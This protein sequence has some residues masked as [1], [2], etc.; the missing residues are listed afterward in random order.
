MNTAATDPVS[1]SVARDIERIRQWQSDGQHAQALQAAQ[2]LLTEAK[3]HYEVLY[4]VARS[5]RYLGQ[6]DA[7]LQTLARM[8][9]EHPRYSRLHEER[10]HCY[11]VLRDAPNAIDALLHAVNINPALPSSW[12][13][14]E[15]LYRMTGDA[16]NAATA[17]SHVA[18]L[19]RLAPDVVRATSHFSDG[20]FDP[21]EQII[22][23][24]LLK[25]G[26]DVEAMRLLA[27]IGLARGVLDDADVLLEAVLKIAPDYRAARYDYACVLFERHLYQRASEEIEK[28]LAFDPNH[29]DYRTLYA[30]ASVGL[31]EHDRAV[32]LYR[33]LLQD[34][35]GAADV[36]LSLAHSLK[37]QGRQAEAIDAYHA[38]TAARPNFGDAYWSL[39]NLKTYRFPDEEIARM[40]AEEASP[41]TPLVDRHHLCFALGKAF[42]D[43][44]DYAE[45]WRYY[46]QGNALKRSES[47][48]RAEIIETNT[49]RQ[50]DV[51]TREFFA[52]R[53]NVGDPRPD[54]IFIVGLPRAG[55]TLL[56][57]ILASHSLVEGTQE[58]ADIPRIVLDLQGR[59]P[60]LD[61]PRYPGVLAEMQAEDFRKLGEKFLHDTRVYRSGKPFFID[62]MPNNFR[63]LGL[64]RLMLPNAKI[65][66]ARREPMACCFSN[67]KQLFATGQEFTYSI[68]DIARY[69]RTYLDLMAHWD[70]VLPGRVLRVY[71]EDVVDDLEGNV[72]RMLDFC[73]LPFEPACLE[74][75]KTERSVRTASSEQVRR[76][77]FRDGID[78]WTKFAPYLGKLK[79]ELGDALVRYRTDG[80][81][82][83]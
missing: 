10:G 70:E 42:E 12:N 6:I 82:P 53:S 13:L 25:V 46:E 14:L 71:H 37:T 65:I 34:A 7:A 11:V 35:P 5:Q 47:R 51:C 49:H 64:I 45:S 55:S 59:D 74:F 2:A 48:Y 28:L 41:A 1:D 26:N 83:S 77:I 63:H 58:L 61:D 68:E 72:R 9:Q 18:T 39:A 44:G 66:D 62:K 60:N 57:Q 23:A 81:Q 52:E 56:E 31:G 27:R 19:K 73:S 32:A 67:L 76:P 30:S 16:A 21:A 38:A 36:H 54:P 17:A 33:Q 50:I 75:H 43:R 80:M 40:R 22:R 29:L 20:E 3:G 79:E 8:E 69:Y 4:L 78:Q 24:Y 15:G